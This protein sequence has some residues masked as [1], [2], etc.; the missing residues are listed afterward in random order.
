MAI[1]RSNGTPHQRFRKFHTD[2][3][4]KDGQKLGMKFCKAVR[5]GNRVFL[6]GQTGSTLDGNFTGYGD[7]A[8]QA[9]QAMKNI[10][11]LLEEAGASINDA[12]KIS[13]YIQHRGHREA[14]YQAIGKHVKGVH[15]CGTGL[16]VDGFAKPHILVEIDVDAVIQN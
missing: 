11:V 1:V 9:D 15:P 4:Y 8:A 10:K 13:T 5:A 16:I 3:E 7:P 14:V 2:N 6:R 12:V